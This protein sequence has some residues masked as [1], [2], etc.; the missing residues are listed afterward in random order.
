MAIVKELGEVT[1]TALL[2]RRFAGSDWNVEKKR[3]QVLYVEEKYVVDLDG[4]QTIIDS[5]MKNFFLEEDFFTSGIGAAMVDGINER[6]AQ[7]DPSE[8]IDPVV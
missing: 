3:I 4:N 1:Q 8:Q 7:A 2:R 6:L 5:Y